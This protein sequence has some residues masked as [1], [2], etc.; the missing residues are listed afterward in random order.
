[1]PS[2]S[3]P[4]STVKAFTPN[5]NLWRFG[6]PN[7]ADQN[8][9][10]YKLLESSGSA[11]IGKI[12]NG[13]PPRVAIV[14]AGIAGLTA[15]RELFRSGFTHIDIF[16][17]GERLGGRNYSLPVP[18]RKT[19]GETIIE[20]G[21]MRFPF[22]AD[23][24]DKNSVMKYYMDAF[25]ITT[26]T[27]PDPGVVRT[28]IYVN[29]GYGPDPDNPLEKPTM[30]MWNPSDGKPPTPTLQAIYDRYEAFASLIEKVFS[31]EYVKGDEAWTKLWQEV[32]NH[33]ANLNFRQMAQL[34]VLKKYDPLKPGYFGGMGLT[35]D[36]LETF[37]LIGAGDGSWGAFFDVGALYI[38]RTLM[39]GYGTNHQLIKGRFNGDTFNPGPEYQNDPDSYIPI[40]DNGLLNTPH[41][42]GIQSFSECMFF[43]P[44]EPGG[45][46]LYDAINGKV[47]NAN[48][49]LYPQT[50]VT[51]IADG[52]SGGTFDL[53]LQPEGGEKNRNRRLRYRHP[54]P[55]HMGQPDQY[56]DR[57]AVSGQAAVPHAQ[58]HE[59]L[60]LDQVVQGLL[61]A[62]GELLV[63]GQPGHPAGSD[64]RRIPPGCLRLR[65]RY[66]QERR[67]DPFLYLG[68]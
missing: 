34:P 16:E 66:R 61:R 58:R 24:A 52:S 37:Y 21:A 5:D 30:L 36:Q 29:N 11:G 18:G 6:W 9:N 65:G 67:R 26:Q 1:M 4:R 13:S 62:Q 49:D 44:L 7:S 59:H 47:P 8:F 56:P 17:S 25:G 3:S 60:A 43:L 27:F 63:R 32:A 10:F 40:N 42:L 64:H 2:F 38:F 28:G 41:Y 20:M 39:C 35:D 33:Y 53:T 46:S 15:A 54:D 14:G 51:E 12:T 22:F 45:A 31:P 48:V 19:I 55:D 68:G 23:P 57:R 50:D